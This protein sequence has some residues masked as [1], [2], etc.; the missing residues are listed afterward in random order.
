VRHRLAVAVVLVLLAPLVCADGQ[1]KI[2]LLNGAN[3]NTT[4]D[5]PISI[6]YGRYTIRRITVQNCSASLTLAVGGFYTGASKTGTTIVAN[7]QVYTALTSAAKFLDVTLAAIITTDVLTANPI[8]L[9]LT[10]GQ[11]SAATCNVAIFG[12]ILD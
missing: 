2:G 1:G 8:Y 3:F 5:Q 11:G 12:D 4:S 6:S 7:T 9:S 10:T